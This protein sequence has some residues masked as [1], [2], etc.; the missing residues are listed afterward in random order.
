MTRSNSLITKEVEIIYW[1]TGKFTLVSQQKVAHSNFLLFLFGRRILYLNKL[2]LRIIL[3][4]KTWD[5]SVIED[6]S[7]SSGLCS[8]P[9]D[10]EKMKLKLSLVNQVS[11]L[12]SSGRLWI[13]DLLF[14]YSFELQSYCYQSNFLKI[15]NKNEIEKKRNY[16][17][18]LLSGMSNL[19]KELF[20]TSIFS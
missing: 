15:K 2:M 1:I 19:V 12:S 10:S 3:N 11:L 8:S 4:F 14:S 5:G 7:L 13:F 9:D 18:L 20:R 17:L 16:Y 6:L